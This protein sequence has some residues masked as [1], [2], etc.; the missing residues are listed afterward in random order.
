MEYLLSDLE[1]LEIAYWNIRN[2]L[3]RNEA[4]IPFKEKKDRAYKKFGASHFGGLV[5]LD[6][7]DGYWLKGY[8]L[9]HLILNIDDATRT[10]LAG[11]FSQSDST[12]NNLEVIRETIEKYGL[13]ALYSRDSDSKFKL[14]LSRIAF[15]NIT[16]L[17]RKRADS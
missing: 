15:L 6:T 9:L 16:E 1:G 4:Y 3:I 12:L 11:G 13:P 17:Q 5:Y 8:P 2:I 10:I 7:S 14:G